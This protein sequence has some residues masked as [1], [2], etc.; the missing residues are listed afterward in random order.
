MRHNLAGAYRRR[1][2]H[3][4][5]DAL[6]EEAIAIGL[7]GDG[8]GNVLAAIAADLHAAGQVERAEELLA[9]EIDHIE[10]VDFGFSGTSA[11]VRAAMTMNRLD[12]LDRLYASYRPGEK[13]LLCIVATRAGIAPAGPIV[14]E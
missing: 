8:D 10:G 4:R 11:I 6:I 12:L 9:K 1:G 2:N 13:M 7:K 14:D 3:A 5:A